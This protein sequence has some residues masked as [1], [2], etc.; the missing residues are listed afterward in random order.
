MRRTIAAS[1]AMGGGVGMAKY[2]SGKAKATVGKMFRMDDGIE[3][4]VMNYLITY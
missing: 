2:S 4:W 1:S 3:L